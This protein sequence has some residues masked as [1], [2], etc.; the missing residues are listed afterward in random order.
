MTI[1]FDNDND[2]IVY[3]LEKIISYA[4]DNQYV[5]LAQSIWWISSILKLQQKLVTHI[6]NLRIQSVVSSAKN[7]KILADSVAPIQ[8]KRRI[9]PV[10]KNQHA[11][12]I[13]A[14]PQDV[15]EASRFRSES[16][17]IHPDRLPQINATI[18]DI[19]DLD[20]NN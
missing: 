18:N 1:T 5:F 3:A 14:A 10:D 11:R 9:D 16:R 2:I 19:S 15:Q 8:G 20:L 12:E 6:D 4:R 13:S 7:K 17:D